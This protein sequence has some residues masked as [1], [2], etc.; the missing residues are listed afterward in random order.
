MYDPYD[1]D[2]YD[3]DHYD[4]DNAQSNDPYKFFFTFDIGNTPL[5]EWLEKMIKDTFDINNITGFPVIKFPVNSWNPNT[6]NDKKF[7][8]LGSNYSG[9]PIW[10]K[11]YFVHDV[12]QSQYLNHLQSHAVYFIQQPLHYK[13]LYDILN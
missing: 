3:D 4:Y 2:E 5:S 1:D 6:A 8:Y 7:Q 12:L 10:K 13:S 9:E 11:K